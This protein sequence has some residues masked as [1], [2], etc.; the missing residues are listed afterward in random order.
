MTIDEKI[1]QLMIV[2]IK[3]MDVDSH[4]KKMIEDYH[5]GGFILFE[6]NILNRETDQLNY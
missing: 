1:G 2:G 3:G 6:K 4:T 5:I